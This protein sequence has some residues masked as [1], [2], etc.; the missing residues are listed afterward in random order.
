M[1]VL[2]PDAAAVSDHLLVDE[3]MTASKP[4]IPLVI[5]KVARAQGLAQAIASPIV[6]EPRPGSIQEVAAEIAELL[7]A[8]RKELLRGL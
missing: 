7:H 8:A 1:G 6:R 5:E 3:P 4:H 2:A